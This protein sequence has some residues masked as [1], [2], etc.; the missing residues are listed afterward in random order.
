MIVYVH[1]CVGGWVGGGHTFQDKN[2]TLRKESLLPIL[3]GF[4][5]LNS[6]WNTLLEVRGQSLQ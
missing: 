5:G 6:H 4:Q 2:T 3:G 1:L